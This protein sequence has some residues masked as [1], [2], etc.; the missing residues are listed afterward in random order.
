MRTNKLK[1]FDPFVCD[2]QK[3]LIQTLNVIGVKGLNYS[4]F[5]P[6]FSFSYSSLISYHSATFA[7]ANPAKAFA[8]TVAAH[9]NFVAVF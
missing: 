7:E 4:T 3:A 2:Y 8:F 1:P 6:S 9:D 5:H